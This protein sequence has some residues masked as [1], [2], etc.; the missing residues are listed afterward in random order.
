MLIQKISKYN[1]EAL[2]KLF[3]ELWSD[4]I[5]EEEIAHCK[6]LLASEKDMCFIGKNK[7]EYVAFIH[8]SLRFEHVEGAVQS[9]IGYIEGLYVQP[10][11][12]Q[13]GVGNHLIQLAEEWCKEKGCTQLASDTELKNQLSIN[14][15]KNRGFRETA[16]IV[17]FIKEI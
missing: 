15:H 16:R 12:R 1:V 10:D 9:P 13:V 14:F 4:C 5:L 2:A 11:F 6:Q 8:V 17:T 7:G 3:V